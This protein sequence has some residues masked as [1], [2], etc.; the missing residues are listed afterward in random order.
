MG[1]GVVAGEVYTGFMDQDGDGRA[2]LWTFLGMVIGFKL[3]TSLLIFYL[4]PSFSSAVFLVGMNWYW[5]LLPL[6]LLVVPAM[7]WFRLRRVRAKRRKLILAEWRVDQE[8]DR[9]SAETS[10]AVRTR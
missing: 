4:E 2:A 6:L 9:V 10:S 3:I 7:F 1:L 8:L 5:P